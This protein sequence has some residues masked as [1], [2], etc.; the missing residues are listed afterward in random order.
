MHTATLA[1]YFYL[2][3]SPFA[4]RPKGFPSMS[5]QGPK[6]DLARDRPLCHFQFGSKEEEEPEAQPC[7]T[8]FP[9]PRLRP[10]TAAT[11]PQSTPIALL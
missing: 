7:R 11:D 5:S 2:S 1:I 6:Q 9:L 4:N 3:L 10:A 8:L